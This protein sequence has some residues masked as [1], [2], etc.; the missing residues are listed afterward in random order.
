MSKN[1]LICSETLKT[2]GVE[3]AVYN[4]AIA[5]KEK[6]NNVYILSDDGDY[7]KDL[8]KKGIKWLS[9]QFTT[10]N[11][12]DIEKAEKIVSMIQKENIQEIHVHKII[13]IPF[14]LMVCAKTKIPYIV[15]IHEVA[16]TIY[17]WFI[18]SCN[19]LNG[20]ALK[21]FFKNAYKIICITNKVK[22]Y[23]QK[24]FKLPD[25]KYLIIKNS[26]NFEI[27]KSNSNIEKKLPENFLIVSRLANEKW[28]SVKNA[29]EVFCEYSDK[30]GINTKLTIIGE[31]EKEEELRNFIKSKPKNYKIEYKG[32]TNEVAKIVNENDVIFG[33]GRCVLEA[34]A[35]KRI[36]IISGYEKVKGIVKPEN[37]E[38]AL[39]ENLS[40]RNLKDLSIEEQVNELLALNHEKIRNITESNYKIIWEELNINKN[41]YNIPENVK[42]IDIN[43]DD[44]YL[45]INKI[46]EKIKNLKQENDNVWNEREY[47]R[48]QSEV[49]D[50][51]IENLRKTNEVLRNEKN[52]IS[53]ENK[54]H[55]E[56]LIAIKNRKIYK[57]L[58]KITNITKIKF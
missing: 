40:G 16:P 1:I 41:I 3:T 33:L 47:F 46:S 48:A 35:I 45:E 26:I 39:E 6:G 36:A 10:N 14:M 53:E 51:E 13:C 31:G 19:I 52:V 54:N 58:N 24:Q 17:D 4:Q 34:M 42:N 2:G 37:L 7:R 29:V 25:D 18:N 28:I 55:K 8:E 30:T 56:E 12:F 9:H 22:E 5:L 49:K 15:Y 21:L 20:L 57:I 11:L 43:Y 23:N 50:R 27:Y 38:L 44:I 32:A